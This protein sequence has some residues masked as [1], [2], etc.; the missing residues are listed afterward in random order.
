[1]GVLYNSYGKLIK[2]L[3]SVKY[4]VLNSGVAKD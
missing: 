3:K 4:E 2:D 1:M